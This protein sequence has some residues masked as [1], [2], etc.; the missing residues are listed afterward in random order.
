MSLAIADKG[1]RMGLWRAV[2]SKID[3][4]KRELEIR[5]TGVPHVDQPISA[6]TTPSDDSE[7]SEAEREAVARKERSQARLRAERVPFIPHLPWIETKDEFKL[8]SKEEIAYRSLALT[9]VAAKTS[10][11][12]QPKVESAVKHLGLEA[13]FTPRERKFIHDTW[14]SDDEWN[15]FS[16]AGEAAWP[17]YWA[18]G[19]VDKLDRPTHTVGD[20]PLAVHAVQDHGVGPYIENAR[21]RSFDEVLDETDLIYR[22]HWAVRDA[23]LHG[24]DIPAGLNPG[25]VQERH[26]ALNWLAVPLDEEPDEW[27]EWDDV[28]TST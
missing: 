20:L 24:R 19:Y 18:L 4:L 22:Y 10:G 3:A 21:L 7:L 6:Q 9:V 28:D 5:R 25:V 23:Y 11:L 17:L 1:W 8:R 26:H 12:F 27:P 2:R 16:W 14:P 13:H 15:N